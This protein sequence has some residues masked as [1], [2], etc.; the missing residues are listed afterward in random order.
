M[1]VGGPYRQEAAGEGPWW[2]AADNNKHAAE[3]KTMVVGDKGLVVRRFRASFGGKTVTT[4]TFSVL[5]DKI[6]LGAPKGLTS[7]SKGDFVDMSIEVLVLP[8]AG[9][10]Y[11][12]A[13]THRFS[14]GTLKCFSTPLSFRDIL[15][16]C[17]T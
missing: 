13:C 6:E 7:L 4:P 2:F 3:S 9:N 12:H 5:C 11:V 17:R 15:C 14:P 8:R 1:Y 10:E 16:T